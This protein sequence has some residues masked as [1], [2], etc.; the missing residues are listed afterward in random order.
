VRKAEIE[1]ENRHLLE[2]QRRF[3]AAADIV[4]D[5]W[6]R[7]PEIRAIAVIGS[8]AAPLWKEVPRFRE[9]RR[10]GIELW[11]ECADLDLAVWIDSR[12]R[13]GE[14]RRARDLALR[15]AYRAGTGA[16]VVGHEVDTFLFE[17][18]TDRYLGR[19][20]SYNHCPKGKRDCAAPGCGAV[21]FNKSIPGFQPHA[22]LLAT[23][24]TAMLYERTAGRLRYAVDLPPTPSGD[25]GASR[26]RELRGLQ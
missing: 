18:H 25:S 5:A 26:G 17:P 22:D 19:L 3:R 13:L 11:H 24:R 12:D 7:F 10:R 1:L 23:A 15:D 9:F 20:C 2:R 14:L 6:M 21:A 16:G 4:T 8:V